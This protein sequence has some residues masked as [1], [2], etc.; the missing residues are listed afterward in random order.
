LPT[1]VKSLWVDFERTLQVLDDVQIAIQARTEA[2]DLDDT[3]VN[4]IVTS[5]QA[6]DSTVMQSQIAQY[7]TKFN[8]ALLQLCDGSMLNC[9]AA[10]DLR[11]IMAHCD[12]E[13]ASAESTSAEGTAR[14]GNSAFTREMDTIVPVLTRG[15]L[16]PDPSLS[17]K[18]LH[19]FFMAS[20][21]LYHV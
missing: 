11:L 15:C 19:C 16:D 20:R 6:L 14:A 3:V 8:M 5:C 1:Q 2:K 17:A 12:A 18:S 13:G 7:R 10:V 4:A 9:A 21:N